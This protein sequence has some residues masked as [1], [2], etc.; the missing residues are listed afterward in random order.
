MGLPW[1][2][3]DLVYRHGVHR[4][5]RRCSS[6]LSIEFYPR[7]SCESGEE[8]RVPIFQVGDYIGG[9]KAVSK[10]NYHKS[11][12]KNGRGCEVRGIVLFGVGGWERLNEGCKSE[13]QS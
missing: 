6:A 1:E 12:G 8:I 5:G 3:R 7:V 9:L 4:T 11:G 13:P 10:K 2:H